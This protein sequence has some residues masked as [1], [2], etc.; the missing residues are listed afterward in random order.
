MKTMLKFVLVSALLATSGIALAGDANPVIGTWQLD[1]A[2]STFKPGPAPKSD[3]RTY[4]ETA[5]GIRMTWKSTGADGKEI[6]AESTFKADGKD[7]P[8]KG[9]PNFD[10]LSLTQVDSHTVH[11]V[12]KKGGKQ[13]GEATRTVSADGKTLT[14]KSKG[15]T[16]A[17]SPY[18]NVMVYD[19][20]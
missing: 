3:M 11:S 7:Y 16:S 12:Q 13:V 6:V 18:D 4:E 2:K 10:A 8:V 1:V 14:L 19:R 15:V 5:Q 20:K 17:G 9:A